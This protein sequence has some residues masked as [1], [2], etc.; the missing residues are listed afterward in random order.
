MGELHRHANN[1]Q[2]LQTL[3]RSVYGDDLPRTLR[4]LTPAAQRAFWGGADLH[5]TLDSVMLTET[6]QVLERAHAELLHAPVCC[7]LGICDAAL[8]DWR[9]D[10][11]GD[12]APEQQPSRSFV[13]EGAELLR[14]RL[15]GMPVPTCRRPARIHTGKRRRGDDTDSSASSSS[16]SSSSV[17]ADFE[18]PE[19]E[20]E[21]HEP[22]A[23]QQRMLAALSRKLPNHI[24]CRHAPDLL[25]AAATLC[26]HALLHRVLFAVA[27]PCW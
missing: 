10:G 2:A 13:G 15:A 23:L 18:Q 17:F 27:G 14:A 11:D 25:I 8:R 21:Q 16:S 22:S 5:K 6:A 1:L 7:P 4:W 24:R 26:T 19:Q 12:E 9:Q 20:Q 3:V